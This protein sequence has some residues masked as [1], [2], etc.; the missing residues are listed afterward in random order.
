MEKTMQQETPPL[1]DCTLDLVVGAVGMV[2]I[3]S[4]TI[5]VRALGVA[6]TTFCTLHIL[7]KMAD[8]AD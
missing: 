3:R 4:N 8:L 6:I 1:P 5:F 2:L 7:K